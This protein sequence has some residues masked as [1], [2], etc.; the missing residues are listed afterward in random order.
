M[1]CRYEILNVLEFTSDRK[2]MSVIVRTSNGKIKLY[3]KGADS[4]IY[5]RLYRNHS[6]DKSD[7]FSVIT[8]THL[9]QFASEGLR[10]LCCA[11]AEIDEK[12]YKAWN[13]K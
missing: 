11:V 7:Q 3:I 5:S 10:T 4:T 12:Q 1:C 2:R 8:Q 6:D 9:T 13:E